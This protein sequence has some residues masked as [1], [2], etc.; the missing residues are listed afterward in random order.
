[1]FTYYS[2]KI[3][4]RDDGSRIHLNTGTYITNNHVNCAYG[5]YWKQ[6]SYEYNSG[7]FGILSPIVVSD[8]IRLLFFPALVSVLFFFRCVRIRDQVGTE[9]IRVAFIWFLAQQKIKNVFVP[10]Q[11]ACLSRTRLRQNP[12]S[13]LAYCKQEEGGQGNGNN[14]DMT[15]NYW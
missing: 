7:R 6:Q 13:N 14:A 3:K 12:T 9:R 15:N 11:T 10:F 1:M 2:F 8:S 5:I 4:E